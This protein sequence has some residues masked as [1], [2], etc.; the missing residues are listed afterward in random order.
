MLYHQQWVLS[1]PHY[2]IQLEVY[3][4]NNNNNAIVPS[5][6]NNI[7]QQP[8]GIQWSYSSTRTTSQPDGTQVTIITR[9]SNGI[10]ETTKRIQFPDGHVEETKEINHS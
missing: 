4:D 5:N 2:P 1:L 9:K 7:T 8:S 3:P 6:D 10:S